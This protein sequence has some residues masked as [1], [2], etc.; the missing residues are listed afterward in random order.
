MKVAIILLGL[1]G[2]AMCRTI[3]VDER[4]IFDT[5]G[6]SLDSVVSALQ[7]GLGSDVSEAACE[8]TCP[9][10][11]SAIPGGSLVAGTLCQPACQE[12][13]KLVNGR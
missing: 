9:S 7:A 1:I 10:L 4:F 3:E 11:I 12:L 13:Q 2:M 8:A 6:L 5:F